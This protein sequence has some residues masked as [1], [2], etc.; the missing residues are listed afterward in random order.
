MTIIVK[1]DC[2]AGEEGMYMSEITAEE[3]NI[4]D[5]LLNEIFKHSGYF[6]T[7]DKYHYGDPTVE[8]LYGQFQG[9]EDFISRIPSPLH[10]IERISEIHIFCEAPVSLY[11]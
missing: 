8:D 7:G 10:G 3:A 2:N 6:P 11:M 4:L 1:V 5:P 9:I